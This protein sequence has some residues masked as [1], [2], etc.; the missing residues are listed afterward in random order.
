MIKFEHTDVYGFEAAI[1]GCRN[2]LN[3]WHLSDSG[4]RPSYFG[5]G[6]VYEI[7]DKDLALMM[8][9]SKAGSDHGKYLRM[10]NVT[11]DITAPTYWVAEH[12]TYKVGT[13]RN[14]CS[15]MHKGVS[16]P[17]ELSDFS[18]EGEVDD[19][20]RDTIDNL[21]SLR[22]IYLE[23]RDESV[24]RRIRQQLPS[25][26]NV[27]YTWQANYEVLKKIY[28]ARKH[29]RLPEWH[30]FCEWIESLPYSELITVGKERK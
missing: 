8:K 20:W 1:R 16:K 7:G 6:E 9:L 21:N 28:H 12:D 5:K 10:I 30:T 17:F 27:R 4:Y 23:T 29:H 24:F 14:S 13:V 2:P 11:V 22:E 18:I 26:Y 3:S 25:G 15:F 19:W